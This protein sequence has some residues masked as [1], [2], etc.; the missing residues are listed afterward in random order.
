MR[1][2]WRASRYSYV[3][4]FFI[5]SA[6]GCIGVVL[7]Y[8][9]Q[10]KAEMDAASQDLNTLVTAIALSVEARTAGLVHGEALRVSFLAVVSHWQS[11][12]P[13]ASVVLRGRY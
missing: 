12:T 4:V 3:L 2:R 9:S 10:R 5:L 11:L 8:Y 1:R 13:Y 6:L 7:L